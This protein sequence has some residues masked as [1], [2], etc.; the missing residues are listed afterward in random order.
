MTLSEKSKKAIMQEIEKAD[1]FI[2]F[3][4]PNDPEKPIENFSN[5]VN[6]ETEAT[7]DGYGKYKECLISAIEDLDT[8]KIKG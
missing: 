7:K 1:N 2:L 4:I 5:L 3:L 6:D 8:I